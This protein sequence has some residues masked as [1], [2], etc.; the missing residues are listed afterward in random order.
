MSKPLSLSSLLEDSRRLTTHLSSS[1]IPAVHRNLDLLESESRKLVARSVRTSSSSSSSAAKGSG[2]TLLDT[3]A[4]SLLASSGVD[5]DELTENLASSALLSAFEMLQPTLD[6]NVESFLAQQQEQSIIN[7]IEESELSTLDDFDRQMRAHMSLVWEESQRRLF[8]ELGQYQ[9][10]AGL[11]SGGTSGAGAFFGGGDAA[12][13]AAAAAASSC[14]FD[15]VDEKKV[16]Q[17]RVE[18]YAKVVRDFNDSRVSAASASGVSRRSGASQ[19]DLLAAFE[20]ATAESSQELRSKQIA[21][22]WKLIGRYVSGRDDGVVQGAC[23]YLEQAFIEHID[24]VVAQYPHEAN[25]GGV[26]SVHRKIEGYLKVLFGRLGRV[27]TFL[28]VF[29][30]DAIW[31][32]MFMLYRCGYRK[33]LL[34]YALEMEDI[35][36]DS[37]PGFVAHLKAFVDRA[38]VSRQADL[39]V[40]ASSLEDPYKAALYK[41]LGR[42]SVPKKTA[43]EV[44]QTTEDYLWAELAVIRDRECIGGAASISAAAAAAGSLGDLQ[45]LMLKFGPTHFDPNGNNPLLYLRVLLLCGL[46]EH[47]V[48]YLLQIDRFQ[49]EAVHMAVVLVHLG[50]LN[51]ACPLES[52][53]HA[54]SVCGGYLVVSSDDDGASSDGHHHQQQLLLQQKKK[55]MMKQPALDFARVVTQ[56]AYALPESAA[57]DAINYLLLLTLGAGSNVAERR[58]ACEQAIVRVLYERREYAHFLGDINAD[59]TR[60]RGYLERYLPLLGI[61][62]HEQLSQTIIRRLADRSRD[63]GRL[64]DTV[65]LYNLGERYNTVLTVLCKQLGEILYIY[66]SNAGGG[67]SIGVS[68]DFAAD[69]AMGLDDV[70]GVARAV[71]AHYKQREHIAQALD[72]RAVN[73]CSALLTVMDFLALHRKGAYENALQVIE[74]TQLLPLGEMVG[75]AE[76]GQ[77]A[78]RV[79]MLDDAITRNFALILVSAMDTLA[80]LYAGLKESSFLDSVKQAGMLELRKKARRLM[81]FAGM[82]QFR[83]PSDTYA[84]LNR[85][86]VFMN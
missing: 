48:D 13:A 81:V 26:P 58:A 83:M 41:V 42:G 80:K 75:T 45:A 12:A 19:Y 69:N 28:E 40:T 49:V 5:T 73:T 1:E 33:E 9:G 8:E 4:Q 55:M 63:E 21:Q 54:Q 20:K 10:M 65:L 25:V 61:S 52:G 59:G 17:P 86:D 16:V 77:Y 31:A 50:L 39:S 32:H 44:I 74:T 11:G 23:D 29:N 6:A 3:R 79:K 51:T 15:L 68:S 2:R 43:A 53:R 22:V 70:E 76:V 30:N 18:R 7:A 46:F 66:G 37:D 71:L 84:K 62:S 14:V 24:R 85:M 27:P 47:A 56:Y 72:V 36:T 82:I 67:P 64:A 60:Q 78:E 38:P 35:I 57:D 34:K